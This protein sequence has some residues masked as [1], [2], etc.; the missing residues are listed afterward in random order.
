MD[1]SKKEIKIMDNNPLAM[2]KEARDDLFSFLREHCSGA[3]IGRKIRVCS[4]DSGLDFR[5]IDDDVISQIKDIKFSTIKLAWDNTAHENKF[6]EALYRLQAAFP[7]KSS[8]GLYEQFQVYVLYNFNDDLQD[9]LYRVEKLYKHYRVFPYSMK[10]VP[11]N[12]LKYK[13]HVDPSWTPEDAVDL[14][15]WCNNRQVFMTTDYQNYVG[16]TSDGRSISNFT[17]HQAIT[18]QIDLFQVA[19]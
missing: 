18:G 12:A 5:R 3:K 11:T 16:R 10:F 4:F 14:G 19:G 2:P 17:H 15:R 9:A 8:R 1:L 7:N 6:T 13:D